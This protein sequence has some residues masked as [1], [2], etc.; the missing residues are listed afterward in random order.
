M[1]LVEL[2]EPT[3]TGY[4]SEKDDETVIHS[5]DTRKTRLTFDRL[6]RLRV[7][8]DIRKLE[9]EKKIGKLADQYKPPAAEAGGLSV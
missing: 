4:R 2:F 1:K 8:N 7:M 3:P 9:N 5:N 6:H